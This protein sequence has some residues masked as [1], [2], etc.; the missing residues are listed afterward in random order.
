MNKFG[1]KSSSLK[2][3][4]V[5]T[6]ENFNINTLS[7]FNKDYFKFLTNVRWYNGIGTGTRCTFISQYNS[8]DW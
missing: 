6:F 7:N 8:I 1:D 2:S 3:A 4:G 5:D